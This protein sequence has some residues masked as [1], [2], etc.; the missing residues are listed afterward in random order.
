MNLKLIMFDK[1]CM[2]FFRH[3]Q[4]NLDRYIWFCHTYKQDVPQSASLL[5]AHRSRASRVMCEA[6]FAHHTL[7]TSPRRSKNF[8]R[9]SAKRENVSTH[10]KRRYDRQ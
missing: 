6:D 1:Y 3:I 4:P 7:G 10:P 2:T 8:T 9:T 5:A